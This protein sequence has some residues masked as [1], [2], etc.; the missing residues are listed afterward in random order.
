[1]TPVAEALH[2]H[3]AF[4]RRPGEWAFHDAASAVVRLAESGAASF[5]LGPR[6]QPQVEAWATMDGALASHEYLGAHFGPL[7][8]DQVAGPM[9]AVKCDFVGSLEPAEQLARFWVRPE[10][11]DLVRSIDDVVLREMI[12]DVV[13]QHALR[14]D[15]FRRG[16]ASPT[17]GQARRWLRELRL[18]W[19]GRPFG[20]DPVRTASGRISLDSTMYRPLLDALAVEDL[21]VDAIVSIVDG[22]ALSDAV[23]AIAMLIAGGYAAPAVTGGVTDTAFA[24][25]RRLNEV[26]IEEN[27]LGANHSTLVA[28]AIGAAVE[29]DSVEMAA[30]GLLWAGADADVDV[31]AGI[32]FDELTGSGRMVREGGELVADP[33]AARAIV[34]K[35]VAAAVDK[36]HGVFVRLGISATD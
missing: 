15:V 10:L 17:E 11:G 8:F 34:A 6:E 23:T 32:A 2:L 29:A 21:G 7:M 14:R 13:N 30:I 20:E 31:L 16:L 24:A 18:T 19:L 9:S 36:H 35:R 12:R 28:P 4:D 5:P 22:W 1:M 26:L 33:N 3:A 27:R 25:S